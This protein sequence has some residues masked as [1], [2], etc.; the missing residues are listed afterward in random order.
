MTIKM[1]NLQS[2][3]LKGEVRIVFSSLFKGEVKS[4][5]FLPLQG[6]G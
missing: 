1:S 5:Y 2:F 6:G 3:P 4:I